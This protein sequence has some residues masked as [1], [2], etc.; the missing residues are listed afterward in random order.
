LISGCCLD[1]GADAANMRLDV[2]TSETF[3]LRL[4][5]GRPAAVRRGGRP[6]KWIDLM[7]KIH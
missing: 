7:V 6:A 1:A 5:S 4:A 3:R 2:W